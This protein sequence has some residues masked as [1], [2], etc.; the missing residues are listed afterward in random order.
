[1]TKTKVSIK[2]VAPVLMGFFVISFC[3]LVGIGVDRVKLDFG[4]SNT[5]AQLIPSAVFLWFFVLSVPVGI[6]QDRL[7]K[8]NV[9]NIGM[10]I[11]ADR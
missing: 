6:L 1:M 9:L 10:A 3:D 4:L 11:T 2:M 7:G 8:R 5:M